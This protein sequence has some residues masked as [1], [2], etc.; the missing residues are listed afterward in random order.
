MMVMI[1]TLIADL[2]IRGV[3]SPHSEA[4]FDIHVTDTDSQS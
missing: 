4:L 3:W 2:G 1:G